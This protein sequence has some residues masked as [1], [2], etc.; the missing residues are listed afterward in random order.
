MYFHLQSIPFELHFENQFTRS[1]RLNPL[2][3]FFFI[4]RICQFHLIEKVLPIRTLNLPFKI[5]KYT[6]ENLPF[7]LDVVKSIYIFVNDKKAK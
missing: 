3:S 7:I 6:P 4:L 5:F 2:S 1:V